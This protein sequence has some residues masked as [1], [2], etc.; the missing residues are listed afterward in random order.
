[1]RIFL[2][3]H[4]SANTAA[5]ESS[6]IWYSNFDLTLEQMGVE[7]LRPSFDVAEQHLACVYGKSDRRPAE[8][9]TYY[10]ERLWED[11]QTA[12]QT[13]GID[14]FFSYYYSASIDPGVIDR[15]RALGIPTVNFYCNSV[16]Q[17]HLVEDIAPHF[18]Y[19]MFP[20]REA[21]PK[22]L[23]A[24]ANPVHIQMA[25][26]PSFYKPYPVPR[27]YPVTFVGQKYL[28]REDYVGYLLANGVDVRVWGSG[29]QRQPGSQ[30]ALSPYRRARRLIGTL[31]RRDLTG[32]EPLPT[33]R[34]PE[35]RCG[36]PLSDQELV[37]MYSRSLISLG[38]SEVQDRQTGEIKRHIRLRDFEAPMSGAFYLVGYQEELAE[39]YELGNEIACY[40]D[41]DEL[42]DR[43]RYYLDHEQETERIRQAG[44]ARARRDHTWANRFGQ[45]FEVIGLAQR[46]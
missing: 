20:E 10:S 12:D 2:A 3:S 41:R 46:V 1:M 17:F 24:G 36:P 21:M 45:L 26:N 42:L 18:D 13:A 6:R 35:D 34:L 32:Q 16:H 4:S 43:V 11:V 22:Y 9:R 19:C 37:K 5:L 33:R 31:K 39:Y 38:F 7:L 29:W 8:A 28:N 40:D 14:L 27:E 23:A 25:A 30:L 15:I 44:L